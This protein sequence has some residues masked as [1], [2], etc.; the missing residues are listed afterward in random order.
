MKF[1]KVILKTLPVKMLVAHLPEILGVIL[2]K[3]WKWLALK[4]PTQL[5]NVIEVLSKLLESAEVA[6]EAGADDIIE[7]HE[8]E[9]FIAIW[10]K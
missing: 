5:K 10:K 2:T 8:V 1:L 6:L 3:T 9:E 4:K 7:P